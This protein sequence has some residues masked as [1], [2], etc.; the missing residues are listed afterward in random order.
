MS[1]LYAPV[2]LKLYVSSLSVEVI[3]QRGRVG[4][5]R[6]AQAGPHAGACLLQQRLGAAHVLDRRAEIAVVLE[7]F[8]HVGD[9]LRIVEHAVVG[10][11]RRRVARHRSDGPVGGHAGAF[12]RH[13]VECG[14]G[15]RQVSASG[16]EG[17]QRAHGHA[18]GDVFLN[19]I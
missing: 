1:M 18:A 8:L 9:E 15:G 10:D 17:R 4:A 14:A 16:E 3:D 5:G 11:N 7:R 12:F 19:H 2:T 13:G 6:G